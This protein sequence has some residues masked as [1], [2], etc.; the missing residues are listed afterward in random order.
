VRG[1]YIHDVHMRDVE[2]TQIADAAIQI[3]FY[4]DEGPGHPYNPSVSGIEVENLHVG[5][6]DKV[7]EMRGYPDD[8]IRDITLTHCAFDKR[9]GT[10]VV[11]NVEELV[12]KDVT[13]NGEP[14][15]AAVR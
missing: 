4:Y 14:V 11:E 2:V 15:E 10:D 8:P 7:F 5:T 9:T 13:V 3:D 1:G 6:T 12:L